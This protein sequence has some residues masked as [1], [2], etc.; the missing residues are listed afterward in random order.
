MP[1]CMPGNFCISDQKLAK[2]QALG[3][4]SPPGPCKSDHRGFE[5]RRAQKAHASG[6]GTAENGTDGS[7]QVTRN[8]L[9]KNR[10]HSAIEKCFAI[11]SGNAKAALPEGGYRAVPPDAKGFSHR[12]GDTKIFSRRFCMNDSTYEQEVYW[13]IIC[14]FSSEQKESDF[15]RCSKKHFPRNTLK[16]QKRYAKR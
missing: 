4:A 2:A 7:V 6:F 9:F 11:L 16:T 14:Y 5:S 10:Y 3:G 1:K 15:Q 8:F 12:K 13:S